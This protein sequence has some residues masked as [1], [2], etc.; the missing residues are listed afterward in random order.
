THRPRPTT[1]MPVRA[2]RPW[3]TASPPPGRVG[4][5]CARS[6]RRYGRDHHPLPFVQRTANVRRT[7]YDTLVPRTATGTEPTPNSAPTIISGG[8][9]ARGV[10]KRFG[11]LWA[12]RGLDLDVAPG[13]VL[14]LL[15]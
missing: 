15:G 5:P 7:M 14:G 9:C 4:R 1:P 11:D 13:Q 3:P 8:V 12:L 10:G 6:C 2:E